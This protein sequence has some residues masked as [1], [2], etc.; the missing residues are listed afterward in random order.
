MKINP[1]NNSTSQNANHN[2]TNVQEDPN[3]TKIKEVFLL[4][5]AGIEEVQKSSGNQTFNIQNLNDVLGSTEAVIVLKNL[6]N[7]KK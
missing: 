6:G 5:L 1:Q 3:E 7:P 2:Q 4:L